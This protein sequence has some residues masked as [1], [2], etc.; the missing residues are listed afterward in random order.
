M[1]RVLNKRLIILTINIILL[2]IGI[3]IGSSTNK[4]SGEVQ[5]TN[6]AN[7][8]TYDKLVDINYDIYYKDIIKLENGFQGNFILTIYNELSEN[9]LFDL[10]KAIYENTISKQRDLKKVNIKFYLGSVSSGKDDFYNDNLL[11]CIDYEKPL[12]RITTSKYILNDNIEEDVNKTTWVINN[13]NKR[14]NTISVDISMQDNIT[15]EDMLS[16]VK[17]LTTQI[18]ELNSSIIN[19]NDSILS[20]VSNSSNDVLL[21]NSNFDNV[22]VKANY[23]NIV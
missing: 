6:I 2:I 15:D 16:Q 23:K 1:N 14:E 12:N 13:I 7:D 3:A 17:G 11:Y 4:K 10:G 5:L 19:E 22:Y 9:E 21:Y 20:I 18:K 8:T